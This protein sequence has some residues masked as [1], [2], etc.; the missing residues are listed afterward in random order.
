MS[1]TTKI[2]RQLLFGISVALNAALVQFLIAASL[3]TFVYEGEAAEGVGLMW[4]VT[5]PAIM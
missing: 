3:G 5:L 2:S 1:S 4:F